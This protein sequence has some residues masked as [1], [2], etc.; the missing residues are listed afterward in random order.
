MKVVVIGGSSGIGAATAESARTRGWDVVVASRRTDPS[1]DVTDE[2]AVGEF[3]ERVGPLDHLVYTPAA[4]ASG[5]LAEIDLDA[6]RR[7]VDTKLWGAIYAARHAAPRISHEGSMTFVSGAAAW[8]PQAGWTITAATNA[9]IAALARALAVELGPVRVNAIA[10]GIV[11]TPTWDALPAD[12]RDALFERTAA[13]LPVGRIGTPQDLADAI[14][15][16]I[17][18]RFVTGTVLHVDGGLLAS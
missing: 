4:R 13:A 1:L 6:A 10:P 15:F 7:A 5:L 14:L 16:L 9:A 8:R 17:E 2:H 18:N 11:D 3:F 12:A